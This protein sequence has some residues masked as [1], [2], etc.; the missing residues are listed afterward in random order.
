MHFAGLLEDMVG[1]EELPGYYKEIL[2]QL[3]ENSNRIGS[4]NS[5]L[6]AYD[7]E[8][9]IK[10][11]IE[12]Q[13]GLI[14]RIK[15]LISKSDSLVST[16][17]FLPLF[18]EK[19]NL[20]S[21]GFNVEE[22]RLTNSFYDLLASEARQTSYLAIARG[23]VPV[24]HWFRMGR[25]LTVVEGYKGLVSWT[26]TMFEYLMPLLLMRSYRNTLLDETYSFVIRSQKKYSYQ[27]RMPW[28][29]SESGFYSLD[30]NHDYQ[31]KAIGVPWLGLKRGLIEDAVATPY[32]TMLAL[33][34]DP[35]SS[36]ENIR[37][38][39]S[40][41]LDGPYGFYEAVDYTRERL[42]FGMKKA[43]VKSFMAHHQGMS[44]LSLNNCI[45]GFIMQ[46]RFHN[47]P[48][49][50][51]AQLLLE[52][53]VPMNIVFTKEQKEKVVPFRDVVYKERGPVRKI[54]KPDS[55]IPAVHMLTNGSYSVMITDRGTG[56]SKCRKIELNRWREDNSL[57][58][59]G[60]FFYIRNVD[61]GEV[62]SSTLA[63]LYRMPQKYEAVFTTDKASFRRSDGD[64]DTHTEIVVATGENAEIRKLSFKNN[65]AKPCVLEIT[66]Y[67]EAVIAPHAADV[68]HPSFSN[69]FVK[70]GYINDKKCITA[71][72]RG[73]SEHEKSVYLAST[74]ALEGKEI[75]EIQYE[76]DR[77]SFTGR[78][79]TLR[80]P[81][82]MER[83]K[84]LS[85]STGSVL[86][87]VI[88]LRF[89][90]VVDPSGTSKVAFITS[91]G[92]N[93]DGT[94][95]TAIK[96]Q[97]FSTVEMA[98]RTALTRSQ[99]E[100]RYLG[101][102]ASET[103][104]YQEMLSDIFFYSPQKR[105]F[106]DITA[107]NIKGQ[108]SLWA[109]GISGDLPVVLA[110]IKKADD[111]DVIHN[112]LKAHEYWRIKDVRVDLVVL[113]DE[114]NSYTHPLKALL[115]ELVRDSHSN[116]FNRSGGV[117][118]LKRSSLSEEDT[119][120]L[121]SVARL[122]VFGDKGKLIEQ[123]RYKKHDKLPPLKNFTTASRE[124]PIPSP[125]KEELLYFNGIG[126]FSSDGREYVIKLDKD[127]NTPL[128]WSNIISNEDFGF[129]T[130]ESGGG[131]TWSENSRE[132]KLSPWSNDPVSDTRG[133]LLYIQDSVTGEMW[134][135][136]PIPLRESTP[137]TIR[138]GFGYSVFLHD[139]H[140]IK[141]ELIQFIP[142]NEHI[143]LSLLKLQNMSDLDR[144]L[145][146]TFYIR[147]VLGVSDQITA[148]HVKT[149]VDETGVMLIENAYNEEFSGRIAFL[150]CSLKERSITGDRQEFFG[151]GGIERPE[152]LLRE[153][154]SNFT[155]TG[156]DPC[157]AIQVNIEL[158]SK[159]HAEVVFL[160]GEGRNINDIRG[161]CGRYRNFNTAAAALQNIRNV[162]HKRLGMLSVDTPDT[163]MNLLLNGWL[164]YQTIACRIFARSAFYQSGGAFGFRDQL[165][166]CLSV[167]KTQPDLVKRQI[168]LHA[169][170]QFVEGDVQHWWHEPSGKG[171]RTKFSDDLLWLPY[172]VCEYVN[173]TGDIKILDK[174]VGFVEDEEL[175]EF[176][177]ERYS[178]PVVSNVSA[179]IFDH[180]IKT[181]ERSLKF[182]PHGLPLMGSGDWNDG[183]NQ[184][185]SRGKGESVW[186]GWF[187]IKVLDGFSSICE[188]ISENERAAMYRE[189]IRKIT[190]AIEEN[191]W[192]GSWY[193][194]AYFDN[195]VPLGSSINTECRID[196]ISQTW[197][198]ISGAAN[199]KR[200]RE[201]MDSVENYLVDCDSALIK[202]LTPPFDEGDLEPGYI[203]GYVPGVRE[204]GGQYT[205]AA[206]WVI[207]AF[208]M[209]GEGE[210]AWN[211]FQLINPINH[212][213][214]QIEYS[215]YKV[216]PYVMAADVYAVGEHAGRGGWTWYTGSSG[217]MYRAG[218]EN[219]LGFSINNGHIA[220]NPCIPGSWTEFSIK[221]N[222]NETHYEIK[223]SNPEGVENGIV[224]VSMD[225]KE[226]KDGLI[227]LLEDGK[228]HKVTVLMG[229]KKFK[230]KTNPSQ[231][232]FDVLHA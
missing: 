152:A 165:Q 52:E 99:I 169:A 138:H 192:D 102:K 38:L 6:T 91:V 11:A 2:S 1:L 31:Y 27:R 214:T 39:R 202:L 201:A 179:T 25:A 208:A 96:Y 20:F 7:L 66:S 49:M 86:D 69:L 93:L 205:H 125:Q 18:V 76:T 53:K 139:S 227:P 163:S 55:S 24:K 156:V 26:G 35:K 85:N 137:Y 193:R 203:K 159:S 171:T 108:S 130:T 188:K 211:L 133:E 106:S 94:V 197:G 215:R 164:I 75:G 186:L 67:F 144:K 174:K 32:A 178:I 89:R 110:I 65:G 114:E 109:F 115:E 119:A 204:N 232:S 207:I 40:E 160:L 131:Y 23:E 113:D 124:Y 127:N 226:L 140:G 116:E 143:K 68:A 50:K 17:S 82:S 81:S 162:W 135:V 21:I 45:N 213:R 22:G 154:L 218:I 61:T 151:L 122:V 100:A 199:V 92:E 198:V 112:L 72:R 195:G 194:R 206:A 173:V 182:G 46:Q 136:T 229:H 15:A 59:Y 129:L 148:M 230:S 37:L 88:C 30:V 62:W 146:V 128:P 149:S 185:G 134:G 155:G 177:D 147:P 51:A 170:H 95:E 12:A 58:N 181:L 9:N 43:V 184:V 13:E 34:V 190:S 175:G 223:V 104:L 167:V 166:D 8:D 105:V 111:L 196:S 77:M 48:Q 142:E 191:A 212:T 157:A 120:L 183:M 28:G 180:C 56:F 216:E 222:Y 103:E 71:H 64:I 44:F 219:I 90:I 79:R 60:M 41:G 16:M 87:P 121:F 126:G 132:N 10:N 158:K 54:R 98:F 78:G 3:E 176:E 168:L 80:S 145:T 172:A 118:V 5:N 141:Q 228:V 225:G 47:D 224:K 123:I 221:Y 42:P 73:R 209:L 117:F 33:M 4:E 189:N 200:V 210:K 63:P 29:A 150:D 97:D 107:K 220:V 74:I 101:L 187:I 36:M 83:N 161:V 153:S 14:R 19:K 84:P 57:D 217:W 231:K 70:T